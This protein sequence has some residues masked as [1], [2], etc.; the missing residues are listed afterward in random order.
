[1][2]MHTDRLRCAPALA[3]VLAGGFVEAAYADLADDVNRLRK[4]GCDDKPGVAAPLRESR[5][6]AGIARE[7]SRGGRLSDAIA[8]SDYRVVNSQSMHI[9]GTTDASKILEI[10]EQN[11]CAIVLNHVF[12]R[13]GI[14]ERG[15]EVWIVVGKPFQA[16]AM[17]DATTVGREVLQLAN[18]ARASARKCGRERFRAVGPLRWSDKLAKAALA[19]AKDMTAHSQLEHEGSDGSKVGDRV[20]RIGYDWQA[21][22]EN[23]AEGQT[24]AAAVMDSWLNSPGHCSNIMSGNFTAM[25][26]AYFADPKSS[27]GI[28]WAQVFARPE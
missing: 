13:I 8:R 17:A 26:V 23:I 7:W 9:Q 1:M 28:Y 20:S 10:I 24:S 12:D 27:G 5:E 14:Y 22:A 2:R 4:S 16:P 21:V 3:L 11:Y 18:K 19:H 6:L 15:A 25:G